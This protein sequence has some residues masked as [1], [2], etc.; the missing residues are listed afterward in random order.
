M[1]YDI[2]LIKKERNSNL[3]KEYQSQ[4]EIENLQN[5]L[6]QTNKE[7]NVYYQ[8]HLNHKKNNDQS[9]SYINQLEL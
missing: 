3:E 7:R 5:K 1:E 2:F 9:K 6:N 8:E 4:L